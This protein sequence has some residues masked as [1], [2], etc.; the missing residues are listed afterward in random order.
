[1]HAQTKFTHLH[2]TYTDQDG[3]SCEGFFFVG[4]STSVV[5]SDAHPLGQ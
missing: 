4:H 3:E 1:M 5:A 2:Q